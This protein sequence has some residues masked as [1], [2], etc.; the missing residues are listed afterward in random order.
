MRM[1]RPA[2]RIGTLKYQVPPYAIESEPGDL[3][4]FDLPRRA[5]LGDTA[6]DL[7]EIRYHYE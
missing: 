3:I 4:A 5:L 6:Q 1:R 2:P 7:A